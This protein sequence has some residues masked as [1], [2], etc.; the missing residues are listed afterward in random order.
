MN[1]AICDVFYFTENEVFVVWNHKSFECVLSMKNQSHFNVYCQHVAMQRCPI[2]Y[3]LQQSFLWL[4]SKCHDPELWSHQV[5]IQ[6]SVGHHQ[7]YT[8]GQSWSQ[9]LVWYCLQWWKWVKYNLFIAGYP[10]V[11]QFFLIFDS[12]LKLWKKFSHLEA[13][14][15]LTNCKIFHQITLNNVI[16]A[17]HQMKPVHPPKP[18]SY[19]P[20]QHGIIFTAAT[21]SFPLSHLND[22]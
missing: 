6:L 20:K 21:S 11:C 7:G 3:Q 22:L 4:Q 15:L 1:A 9:M 18:H 17:C 10:K 14:G 16:T 2:T 8:A 5:E 12:K 19:N 13:I